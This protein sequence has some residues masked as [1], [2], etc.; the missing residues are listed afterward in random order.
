M[1]S[2]LDKH[3]PKK[4]KRKSNKTPKWWNAGCQKATRAKRQTERNFKH[5]RTK[6]AKYK[7]K[8]KVRYAAKS[9]AG[10]R[11]R[12]FQTKLDDATRRPKQVFQIVNYLP[13]RREA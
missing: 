1:R 11:N 4:S 6:K 9:T 2:L 7:L 8:E 10:A 13:V 12:Y 3:A 5:K